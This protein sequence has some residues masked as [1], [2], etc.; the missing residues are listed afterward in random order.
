MTQKLFAIA[1]ALA[2]I[3]TSCAPSTPVIQKDYTPEI[4]AAVEAVKTELRT[5]YQGQLDALKAENTALKAEVE[6]LKSI[7]TGTQAS[8]ADLENRVQTLEIE[9]VSEIIPEIESVRE[10]VWMLTNGY[11]TFVDTDGL[12]TN[13]K[14]SFDNN[15]TAHPTAPGYYLVNVQS[16]TLTGRYQGEAFRYDITP[17]AYFEVS[18]GEFNI[19]YVTF[20]Q[21][22]GP[23]VNLPEPYFARFPLISK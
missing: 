16:S 2:I 1:L 14:L 15:T 23:E 11:A 7:Q 6:N 10:D 13:G 9:K 3:L 21:R 20:W 22:F 19:V 4:T 12:Y 17:G 18:L 5:E 8:V